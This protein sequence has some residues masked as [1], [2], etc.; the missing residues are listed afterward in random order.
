MAASPASP[1]VLQPDVE[2]T[3]KTV[4][5]L[6]NKKLDKPRKFTNTVGAFVRFMQ[7]KAFGRPDT[8]KL[9]MF[10]TLPTTQGTSS[11]H[12]IPSPDQTLGELALRY[13]DPSASPSDTLLKLTV[14]FSPK[15]FFG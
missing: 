12:F 15:V 3:I 10:V 5:G 14:T 9:F 8:D 1:L 13:G 2:V 11:T 4:G 7:T 6:T